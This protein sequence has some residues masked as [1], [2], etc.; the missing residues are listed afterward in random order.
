M[1]KALTAVVSL[2]ALT[3]A[4]EATEPGDFDIGS[5]QHHVDIHAGAL[6]I[7]ARRERDV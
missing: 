4:A 7:G 6:P 3:V 2:V 1:R 5:G